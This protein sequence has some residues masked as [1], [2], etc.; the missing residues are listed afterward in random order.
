MVASGK[1]NWDMSGSIAEHDDELLVLFAV[2][3]DQIVSKIS[4]D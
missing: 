1:D 2:V 4:I 3:G